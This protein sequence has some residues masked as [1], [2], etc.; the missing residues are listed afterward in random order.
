[1]WI[2]LCAVG[3]GKSDESACKEFAALVCACDGSAWD[4]EGAEIT[5][6]Q[7]V[8]DEVAQQACADRLR[9]F[10]AEGGCDEGTDTGDTGLGVSD[11]A[12]DVWAVLKALIFDHE[13]P[14]KTD[15]ID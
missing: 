4:C 14:M 1:M 10:E 6:D 8:G 9:S 3:C 12:G 2:L 11:V 7:A 13:S 15:V 5:A